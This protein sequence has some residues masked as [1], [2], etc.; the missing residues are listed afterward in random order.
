[1]N[2]YRHR[3]DELHQFFAGYFHQDWSRVFDWKNEFPNFAPVV[4][5]FKATNPQQT[6]LKVRNQLEDFI[7]YDLDEN[8]LKKALTDLG[9]SYFPKSNKETYKV[10]LKNILIILDDPTEKGLVLREIE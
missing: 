4:R 8:E 10:W 6:I 3:F 5:H 2:E 9:S 1:M 7:S